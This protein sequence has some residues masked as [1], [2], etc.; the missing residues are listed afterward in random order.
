[1]RRQ[2]GNFAGSKCNQNSIFDMNRFIWTSFPLCLA[3]IRCSTV[4]GKTITKTHVSTVSGLFAP[5]QMSLVVRKPVF[6]VSDQVPHKP[7]LH[8]QK[9]ARDL[10]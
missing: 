10:K 8:P 2:S 1:M 4:N 3:K 7:A 6:G 5:K 9:M